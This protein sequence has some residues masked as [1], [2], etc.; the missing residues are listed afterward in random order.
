MIP[1]S[2]ASTESEMENRFSEGNRVNGS[3]LWQQV[4]AISVTVISL[5][6]AVVTLS[7]DS[8]SALGYD[9]TYPMLAIAFLGLVVLGSIV[10]LKRV[11]PRVGW[12][13]LVTGLGGTLSVF[14]ER[15]TLVIADRG[16][17]SDLVSAILSMAAVSF[18]T[19]IAG[20]A[21]LFLIFP[22]GTLTS[23]RWMIV[24]GL[25][26]A[27][28]TAQIVGT[29]IIIPYVSDPQSFLRS[30]W[31]YAQAGTEIPTWATTLVDTATYLGLAAI[32]LGAISLGLRLRTSSGVERQQVK[33]VVYSGAAAALGWMLALSL[34]LAAEVEVV[35]AGFGGMALTAGLAISLFRYRLY[36]I[37]RVISRT[38]GYVGV[39]GLLGLVYVAGAIWL[40]ARLA[41]ESPLFVAGSTLAVAALFNPIRRRVLLVVD[42]RFYRSRYDARKTIEEFSSRLQDQVDVERLAADLMAVVDTTMKPSMV[43]VWVKDP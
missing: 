10:I 41:G 2:F 38:V 31:D 28:W 34:P 23:R 24:T 36:D 43:S 16:G 7:F 11:A 12:V 1:R 8:N 14:G 30:N 42:R 27:G 19:M 9:V 17:S 5:A 40:P 25:A 18:A 13:L 20:T 22:N 33:W 3:H 39:V 35:P 29:P 15:M 21:I 37:D 32:L 4:V 6:A 26:V